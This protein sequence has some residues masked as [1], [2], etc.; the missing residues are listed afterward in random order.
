MACCG[1][2]KSMGLDYEL[3][4]QTFLFLYGLR[5]TTGQRGSSPPKTERTFSFKLQIHKVRLSQATDLDLSVN[6][7]K[8][9]IETHATFRVIKSN[10][11]QGNLTLAFSDPDWKTYRARAGRYDEIIISIAIMICFSVYRGFRQVLLLFS[12]YFLL[13]TNWV[14]FLF[15]FFF[16]LYKSS[17]FFWPFTSLLKLSW[18]AS[19]YLLALFKQD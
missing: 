2:I 12:L 6:P 18:Y 3:V 5:V 16:F 14:L 17:F 8:S 1:T 13:L 9:Q 10:P 4:N 7:S 15:F 11:H 19:A